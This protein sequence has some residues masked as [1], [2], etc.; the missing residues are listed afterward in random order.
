MDCLSQRNQ[1]S[2]CFL[3]TAD[4]HT[5]ADKDT[6]ADKQS[7]NTNLKCCNTVKCCNP[8]IVKNLI[9]VWRRID[10]TE[11]QKQ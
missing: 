8:E 6:T 9:C 2:F 3:T 7:I 1:I 11:K 5:T 4:K 10:H